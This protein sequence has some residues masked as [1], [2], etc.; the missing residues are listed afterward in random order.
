MTITITASYMSTGAAR[1]AGDELISDGFDQEKVFVDEDAMEV[2]VMV[3]GNIRREVE[4][5]LQR[6]QPRDMHT[7]PVE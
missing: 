5:I 1:N 3:S 6:H 7:T 4:E 2:K